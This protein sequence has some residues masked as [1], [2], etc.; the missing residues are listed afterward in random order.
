MNIVHSIM[1]T[2]YHS[3]F[4]FSCDIIIQPAIVLTLVGVL[5]NKS[6]IDKNNLIV[7]HTISNHLITDYKRQM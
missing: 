2:C 6:L 7:H 1:Y 4:R 5:I 3:H